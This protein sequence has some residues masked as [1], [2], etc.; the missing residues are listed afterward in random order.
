MVASLRS[1]RSS[2]R[3]R[4]PASPRGRKITCPTST[5]SVNVLL[6]STPSR[7]VMPVSALGTRSSRS[8]HGGISPERPPLAAE[9]KARQPSWQEDHEDHDDEP[10]GDQIVNDP[11][12]TQP[13]VDGEE[14]HRAQGWPPDR[15]EAAEHRH[16]DHE[17]G[18]GRGGHGGAHEL[19]VVRVERAREAGQSRAQAEGEE[20][21][22][23]GVDTEALREDLVL[24]DGAET[25][26]RTRAMTD[27]EHER[28]A[29][30]YH[31]GDEEIGC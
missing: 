20:L 30:G 26:A 19:D 11:D 7:N 15:A 9:A 8:R 10:H 5:R 14:Q 13:L 12:E 16:A 6:T 21:V 23:R 28:D 27:E 24:P 31:D 2:R 4:R 18:G 17:R 1:D 29:C 3:K 25:A 22:R